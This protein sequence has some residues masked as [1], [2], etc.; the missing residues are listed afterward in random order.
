MPSN[1]VTIAAAGSG[2]TRGLIELALKRP[3]RRTLIIT[4]TNEN[5][6][7]IKKQIEDR[8]GVIPCLIVVQTW[9]PFL[10]Q[11][12]VRPYQHSLYGK[13]RISSIY[14][15]T[16]QRAFSEARRFLKR[17]EISTYYFVGDDQIVG[18]FVSDFVTVCNEA[19][20][21][22][23]IDRLE[24]V[25]DSIYIDEVQDLAGYD[26][27]ILKLL[28][29]SDLEIEVVGDNRQVIYQTNYSKKNKQY[30]D[31]NIYEFFYDLEKKGICE[32]VYKTESYRCN[33]KICDFADKLYPYMPS[34]QSKDVACT[35]HDGVFFISEADIAG[36]IEQ[37]SPQVLRYQKSP[38]TAGL[39]AMN[40]GQAKGSTFDRVLI[41]PTGPIREYLQTG[42]LTKAGDISK[43]YVAVTRARYSVAFVY[44]G[45]V[46]E[47]FA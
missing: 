39:N 47:G 9:Y 19:S 45:D 36:Y 29:A 17:D 32:L 3:E 27:E 5:L 16:D 46:F 25:F 33:Q 15:P 4:Y 43:F 41:F 38:K 23:I 44:N 13:C 40:F 34:T 35:D 7:Q 18:D 1:K 30:R 22:L 24:R 20:G 6:A 21:G 10:L 31:E 2:K 8:C 11:H 12:C 37:Y 42:D 28:F 26:L 14:F